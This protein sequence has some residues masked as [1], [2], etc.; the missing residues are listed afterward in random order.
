MGT[1]PQSTKNPQRFMQGAE[2]FTV[3]YLGWKDK[4][5]KE[6]F[7]SLGVFQRALTLVLLSVATPAEPHSE[8]KKK[9]VQILGG[10]KL[11][12]FGER[13]R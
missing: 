3:S 9:F 11:L 13:C 7:H 5:S 2:Q 6:K 1:T 4:K 8:K 12:K 10:E